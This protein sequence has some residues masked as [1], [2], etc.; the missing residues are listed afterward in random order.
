MICY[1]KYGKMTKEYTEYQQSA[2]D[3]FRR[4]SEEL[5]AKAIADGVCPKALCE[6]MTRA[7]ECGN[8]IA[9]A[10]AYTKDFMKATQDPREAPINY[11]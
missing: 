11:V 4:A 10:N 5:T 6:T 2:W 3:K 1:D 9:C 7:I 8:V